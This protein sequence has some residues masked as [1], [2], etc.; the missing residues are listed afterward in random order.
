MTICV[1]QFLFY[2]KQTFSLSFSYK[3]LKKYE[4]LLSDSSVYLLIVVY[5]MPAKPY[6]NMPK[7]TFTS[8]AY[9]LRN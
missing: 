7:G 3:L 4:E 6:K 2:P 1:T 5:N 8:K 9:R